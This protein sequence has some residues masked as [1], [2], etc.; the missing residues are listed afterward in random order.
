M[1]E[2]GFPEFA[3][4]IPETGTHRLPTNVK[5]TTSAAPEPA[6]NVPCSNPKTL[7]SNHVS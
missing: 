1:D 3:M 4:T 7:H 6:H 5:E 2:P